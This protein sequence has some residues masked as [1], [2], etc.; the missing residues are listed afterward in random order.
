MAPTATELAIRA[1]ATAEAQQIVDA[2]N[3]TIASETAQ[4]VQQATTAVAAERATTTAQ[5][6]VRAT[7]TID[8]YRTNMPKGFWQ[9][10][11]DDVFVLAGDFR[12]VN[13]IGSSRA[14]SGAKFVAVYIAVFN[15]G[16]DVIHVNPNFIT[17][18]DI[19]GR[20]YSYDVASFRYWNQPLDAVDVRPDTS[21]EGGLVFKISANS[22][23]AQIV[24]DAGRFNE[25]VVIDFRRTPDQGNQ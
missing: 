18:I 7:E 14:G 12:Y 10:D 2:T 17:L 11:N 3:T 6:V 24:Y 25:E 22:A 5:A 21:A 1:I 15:R 4:A 23:P 13:S 8:Q 16:G 20:T 9:D 19:D